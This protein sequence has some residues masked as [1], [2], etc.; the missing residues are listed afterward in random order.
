MLF[1]ARIIGWL[2]YFEWRYCC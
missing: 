1:I 2:W